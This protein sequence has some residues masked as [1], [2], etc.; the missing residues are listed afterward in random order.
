ML[1]C[2][3]SKKVNNMLKNTNQ[4]DAHQL[5]ELEQLTALCKKVDGS[6]PNL[7]THILDQPRAFPAGLLYYEQ[8]QL[9]GFLAA[10]FFYDDAVEI[11]LLVHPSYRRKGISKQLIRSILPLIQ[12]QNYS[13]L[14][15]SSPAQLNNLWLY[16]NG[17]TY[18]HSEYYMERDELNPLLDCKQSLTFRTATADD[19]PQLCLFDEAC[20]PQKSLDA[21]ERFQHLI[22]GREYQI[23]IAYQNNIPIGKAHL[24]WQ[25]HGAS[26]SDIAIYPA[27]QGIGLGTS[28]IAY[29]INLALSEGK[30]HLNLDVETHNKRALQLYTRLGFLTKNACDYWSIDANKVLGEHSDG[31]PIM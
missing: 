5:K 17:F 28:L 30:P 2:P 3:M 29:C 8:Q 22:D 24:R 15:F 1:P 13:T 11:A 18:L 26:L 19:I 6:T 20:F 12:S 4:L 7:Y 14:I 27:K 21:T 16:A 31:S 23:L 10:Y 25:T 9:I